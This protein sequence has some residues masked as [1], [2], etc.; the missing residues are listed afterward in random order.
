MNQFFIFLFILKGC[1]SALSDLINKRPES[2]STMIYFALVA[3]FSIAYQFERIAD[4]KDK[5]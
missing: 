5:G 2:Y 4:K 1:L 3:L